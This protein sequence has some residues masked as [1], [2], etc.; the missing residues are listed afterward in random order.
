MNCLV[1]VLQTFLS[2]KVGFLV[3][4]RNW[5]YVFT[6]VTSKGRTAELMLT[7]QR[8]EVRLRGLRAPGWLLETRWSRLKPD[9]TAGKSS[10]STAAHR[11]QQSRLEQQ[12]D[13]ENHRNSQHK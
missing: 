4:Y 8:P 11:L 13:G 1:Q 3:A 9:M 12:H 2:N 6:A 7:Q 5:S 10:S